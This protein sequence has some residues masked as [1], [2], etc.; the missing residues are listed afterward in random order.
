[1]NKFARNCKNWR[2][3]ERSRPDLM[4]LALL[5]LLLGACVPARPPGRPLPT[6]TADRLQQALADQ[7]SRWRSLQGM[8]RLRVSGPDE[9]RSTRQVLLLERPDRFR[10]EVLGPFGQP[11]LVV[12]GD[13]GRLSALA[14]G[15]GRYYSGPATPERL[16]RL[17]RL[18]L[19]LPDVVRLM[20]HDVPWATGRTDGVEVVDG[21]YRLTLDGADG[22]RCRLWFDA[23]LHVR[24]AALYRGEE[25]LLQVSYDQ[26][27]SEDGLPLRVRLTLP[28]LRTEVELEL[29]GVRT[30]VDLAPER[31]SIKV[32]PGAEVAPL[33]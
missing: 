6:V 10:A 3:A 1:M 12:T 16:W 17:V 31:F 15:E 9:R 19:A 4:A 7:A 24:R 14:P 32:P 30:N 13:A 33:P 25:L 22:R 20:L 18:P 2:R 11:L 21:R 26:L 28:T 8:A 5:L 29:S 27:R 23:D